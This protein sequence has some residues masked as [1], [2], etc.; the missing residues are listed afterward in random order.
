ME[1]HFVET[2]MTPYLNE[3]APWE[4]KSQHYEIIR[5]GENVSEQIE[6]IDE[7]IEASRLSQIASSRAIIASQERVREGIDKLSLGVE[8]VAEGIYGLASAFEWGISEVV[9][10][11]EQNREVLKSILEVLMAPLNTQAKERRKRAED[12]FANGWIDDAEEEFLE[13]E[14]LNKFDF[15]IHI[16]LG[17]IYL[18]HKI[19]KEKA[20]SYF[21]K[22]I[23]Y[24]KPKSAYYTSYAL[25]YKGLIKFDF[26]EVDDAEKWTEEAIHLSPDLIE[27]FYENAQYNAQLDNAGKSIAN[28]EIAIKQDKY[29]CLKSQNDPLFNPIRERVNRLLERLRD[30]EKQKALKSFDG[31]SDKNKRLCPIISNLSNESFVDIS[32]LVKETKRIDEYLNDLE[33]RINRDSY[34][35]FLDINSCFVPELQN[36]QNQLLQ[37]LKQ[38]IGDVVNNCE[39]DIKSAETTHTNEIK[40]NLAIAGSAL[41]AGSFIVPAVTSLIVL[42]GLN[43]L[44]FILFCIPVFSQ[45]LSIGMVYYLFTNH[46]NP[47]KGEPVV[48]WSIVIYVLASIC[49]FFIATVLSQRKKSSE[50]RKQSN[51]LRQS[52]PYVQKINDLY[53][54]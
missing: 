29:Y 43:K 26:G 28:L 6:S 9:W 23:K 14:K 39:T 22:A 10:Q 13:S 35:D 11:I 1:R 41:L 47:E 7:Q 34:F 45:I 38:K 5:L 44:T 17:M 31:I 12:A 16:S 8:N 50:V 48:A 18:F 21:E 52:L 24:A 36:T 37:N 2:E 51:I 27:A 25:L 53:K 33:K 40:G 30:E 49:Y 4:R 42:Q 20:L 54:E 15:S 46:P 32:E 3:L 19:D